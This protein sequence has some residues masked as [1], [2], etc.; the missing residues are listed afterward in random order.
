MKRILN[1]IGIFFLSIIVFT[2]C[3]KSPEELNEG[4]PQT[5][6]AGVTGTYYWYNGEKIYLTP[7]NDKQFILFKTSDANSL[8][9][10]FTASAPGTSKAETSM[11]KVVLSSHLEP[12]DENNSLPA[13]SLVQ[14]SVYQSRIYPFLPSIVTLFSS[15]NCWR[16]RKSF[17]DFTFT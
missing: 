16:V 6:A 15:A 4:S 12:I 7:K 9:S 17:I 8:S 3:Q 11:Q 13:D 1:I 10:L 14:E 2:S 5:R